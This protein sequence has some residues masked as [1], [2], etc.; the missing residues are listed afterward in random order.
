M[1]HVEHFAA[2]S[3][4]AA[5]AASGAGHVEPRHAPREFGQRNAP[6]PL[7][8]C[9]RL[10]GQHRREDR[11]VHRFDHGAEK[12]IGVN[13]ADGTQRQLARR[14][15]GETLRGGKSHGD[16]A[17]A[18]ADDRAGV[19]DAGA[20]AFAEPL[21]LAR[22]HG[23]V[24][25]DQH[26]AGSLLAQ[27][28]RLDDLFRFGARRLT[29]QREIVHLAEVAQRQRAERVRPCVGGHQPRSRADAALELVAAHAPSRAHRAER[30][31]GRGG[32]RGDGEQVAGGQAGRAEAKKAG[33]HRHAPDRAEKG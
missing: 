29:V 25:G 26:D 8:A 11:L 7:K 18:V 33:E 28:L 27:P 19:R 23:R 21:Q 1:F 14:V 20:G 13:V 30:E 2:A 9:H 15:E 3:S 10:G 32:R 17:A 24:G 6:V 5:P 31:I 4:A 22:G 16:L 12:Q